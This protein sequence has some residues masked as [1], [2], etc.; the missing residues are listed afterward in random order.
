MWWS[1]FVLS[2]RKD[3]SL[4]RERSDLSNSRLKKVQ[5]CHNNTRVDKSLMPHKANNNVL[6]ELT[7]V[8]KSYGKLH[9]AVN[10]V[11]DV[12]F[13]VCRGERVALLGKSGSIR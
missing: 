11:S 13:V 9:P 8:S 12:S 1:E 6:V 10:A 3:R 5:V 7:G 4:C 2:F